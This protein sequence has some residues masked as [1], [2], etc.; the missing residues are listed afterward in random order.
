LDSVDIGNSFVSRLARAVA[1]LSNKER[2][3]PAFRPAS[4]STTAC[5]GSNSA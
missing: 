5:S 3:A 2:V 1:I 4:R